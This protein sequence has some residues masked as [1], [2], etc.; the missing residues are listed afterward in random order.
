MEFG[1]PPEQKKICLQFKLQN[2]N[3]YLESIMDNRFH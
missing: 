2:K 3:M 1:E